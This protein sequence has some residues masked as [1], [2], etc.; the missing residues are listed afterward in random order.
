M[1][2]VHLGFPKDRI[3]DEM[4]LRQ[5]QLLDTQSLKSYYVEK[6][7]NCKNEFN[8]LQSSYECLKLLVSLLLLQETVHQLC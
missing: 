2:T 1:E 5:N 7:L 3:L 6:M 8:L 4:F